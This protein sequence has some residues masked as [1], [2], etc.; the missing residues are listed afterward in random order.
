MSDIGEHTQRSARERRCLQMCNQIALIVACLV[1]VY[2]PVYWIKGFPKIGVFNLLAGLMI[3][4]IV[5][6]NRSLR[7]PLLGRNLFLLINN[8]LIL[9]YCIILGRNCWPHLFFLNM[10]TV[11][12]IIF[13]SQHRWYI[14]FW[15][16]APGVLFFGM[17]GWG[18]A[19]FSQ[20]SILTLEQQQQLFWLICPSVF[21]IALIY[22]NYLYRMI[23]K[24]EEAL[25]QRIKELQ[26]SHRTIEEQQLHLAA[27]TQFSAVAELSA[28]VAHEI[29][30][31]LAIIRGFAEQLEILLKRNEFEMDRVSTIAQRIKETVDRI[32]KITSSLRNVS[33]EGSED[34]FEEVDMSR[35]IDEVLAISK[36]G[37]IH[38]GIDLRVEIQTDE[39]PCVCRHVQI[40]QVLLSLI[41]NAKD[42]VAELA[43]KWIHIRL[44]VKD[45]VYDVAVIDSG[46]GISPHILPR[47]HQPFFTTKPPG[48]GTGLGLSISRKILIAHHGHLFVDTQAA[49]TTFIMRLPKTGPVR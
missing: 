15:S 9:V 47:I 3:L 45:Q 42:A 37:L 16:L 38:N 39:A 11:A 33:R 49:H 23:N 40:A 36:E 44:E 27:S 29:N 30:N 46:T 7:F 18:F 35:I 2:G 10:M 8:G 14:Q 34:P 4:A 17:E 28:S 6:A 19:L 32:T 43:D 12:Y 5:P 13:P 22:A 20:Y 24:H 25:L 31:P 1:A 41:H 21:A 48:K 26:Q